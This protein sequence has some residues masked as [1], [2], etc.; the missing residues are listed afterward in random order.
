MSSFRDMEYSQLEGTATIGAGMR[1][2]E[3]YDAL[4]PFGVSVLGGRVPG[5]GVAGKPSFHST[6][7]QKL[8]DCCVA[9]LTLG[10]GNCL[11]DKMVFINSTF[12][13]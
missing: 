1:W 5:V 8:V 2:E 4:E 7:S 12:R 13:F 9:G 6:I 10:G 11:V 3:V